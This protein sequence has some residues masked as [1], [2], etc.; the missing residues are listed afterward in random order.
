MERYTP[1]LLLFHRKSRQGSFSVA[2][3]YKIDRCFSKFILDT[4]QNRG[5]FTIII[6]YP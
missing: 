3:D 1:V 6:L 4:L 5:I 2:W